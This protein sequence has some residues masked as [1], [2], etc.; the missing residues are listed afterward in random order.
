[1]TSITGPAKRQRNGFPRYHLIVLAKN[2]DG[3]QNIFAQLTLAN[4]QF[5]YKPLLS[6][7]Q[8]YKFKNCVVMTACAVGVLHHPNYS[9]ICHRLKDVYAGDFYL[10]IIAPSA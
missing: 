7:D 6:L 10:E 4:E 3:L 2:W 5:Y 8:I 1:M 9:A